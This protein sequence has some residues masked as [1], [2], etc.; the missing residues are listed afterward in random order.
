VSAQSTSGVAQQLATLQ[1]NN[2][3]LLQALNTATATLAAQ[4]AIITALQATAV[5]PSVS[6]VNAACPT[7]L[8]TIATAVAGQTNLVGINLVGQ[9]TVPAT[10]PLPLGTFIIYISPVVTAPTITATPPSLPAVK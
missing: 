8:L 5:D 7:C 9:T 6:A 3:A 2:T 10:S 1:A 4:A